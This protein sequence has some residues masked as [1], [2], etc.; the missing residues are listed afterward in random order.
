MVSDPAWNLRH[1]WHEPTKRWRVS[2]YQGPQYGPAEVV[3]P[4]EQPDLTGA[5][6]LWTADV[7]D[8][9]HLLLRINPDLVE[10]APT[11]WF[12]AS[13]QLRDDPATVTLVAFATDD[14]P[15]GTVIDNAEF[16]ALAVR[17]SDQVAAV[18]WGPRTAIIYQV[19]VQPQWRRRQ[20]ATKMVYA[21]SAYHQAHGWSG[22]IRSDGRRTDLG[23]EFTAAFRHP[24][25][26]APWQERAEPM[27]PS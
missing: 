26:I 15:E 7:A 27:D 9:G 11:T 20:L 22:P 8:D 19:F 25:R 5:L 6:R 12:V 13:Q 17:S 24:D 4:E 10:R 1:G 23:E 21:A 16:M 14:L 3:G 2:G 18:Q